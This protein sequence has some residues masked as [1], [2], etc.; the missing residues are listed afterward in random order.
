MPDICFAPPI[1]VLLGANKFA[2]G[3]GIVSIVNVRDAF[4]IPGLAIWQDILLRCPQP[5]SDWDFVDRDA[6]GCAGFL[7]SLPALGILCEFLPT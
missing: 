6:S 2:P 1:L 5:L 3:A 4:F 7:F